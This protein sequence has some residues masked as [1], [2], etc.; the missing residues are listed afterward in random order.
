MF[1]KS[2]FTFRFLPVTIIASGTFAWW[3]L[4]TLYFEEI[5]SNLVVDQ[6]WISIL[7][8]LFYGSGALSAIP[9]S[10]IGERINRRKFLLFNITFGIL[11]TALMLMVGDNLVFALLATA[12]LGISLG[13]GFPSCMAVIADCTSKQVRARF[14]GTMVLETFV[15]ILLGVVALSIL[16]F[17]LIGIIAVAIVLRSTSYLG[18]TSSFCIRP[19][20]RAGSWLS[21]LKSRDLIF[22][23]LPW[24]AFNLAGELV[25]LIWVGLEG[26][27]LVAEAYELGNAIRI[28]LIAILGPVVG[29]AADRIGR[30]TPI[31]FALVILGISFGFLGLATSYYS[32][33]FYM[34]ISGIAWAL[35]MASYFAL[36]GDIAFPKLTER[37]YALGITTPLIAYM[38][39]RG[40]LPSLN[41]TSAE[42]SVLSPIMS[43]LIF[44]SITPVLFVRDTLSEDTI[45][46]RR[47]KEHAKKIGELIE[48]SRN[49]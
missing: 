32:A 39:V 40:I 3:F 14:T 7:A 2:G 34:I 5:F 29:I 18:F 11:A 20:A 33:L 42:A 25:H 41:V 35:L 9:G 28:A 37:Y 17:G 43:I 6:F 22:Y 26:D 45:R 8:T 24:L 15:M 44:L 23:L 46:E 31:I 19:K 36:F 48:E 13:L 10:M 47:I 38:L 49:E 4:L 30:R 16:D 12:L 27:I 1:K 21:L